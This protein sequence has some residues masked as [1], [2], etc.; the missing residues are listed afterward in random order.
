MEPDI[1]ALLE[2]VL[3][4]ATKTASIPIPTKAL[5]GNA[6]L[7]R[8]VDECIYGLLEQEEMSKEQLE[9]FRLLL[10]AHDVFRKEDK[11]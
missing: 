10:Q 8:K 2:T 4:Q 11:L 1:D 9:L 5:T 3:G 7:T 6:S